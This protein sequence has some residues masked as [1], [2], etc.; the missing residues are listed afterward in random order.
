LLTSHAA[1]SL[2][3]LIVWW[4]EHDLALTLEEMERIFWKLMNEGL[5]CTL[6]MGV[7]PTV[8]DDWRERFGTCNGQAARVLDARGARQTKK[9]RIC[10]HP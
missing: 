2:F 10:I 4:Q 6:G 7:N 8:V 3:A 9:V 5:P 1:G